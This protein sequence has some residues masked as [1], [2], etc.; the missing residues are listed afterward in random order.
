MGDLESKIY[1]IESDGTD[2]DDWVGD[3]DDPEEITLS[4]TFTNGTDYIVMEIARRVNGQLELENTLSRFPGGSQWGLSLDI[5][6]NP[7]VIQGIVRTS[8]TEA[9]H[10]KFFKT[11]NETLANDIYLIIRLAS[12]TYK[13]FPN[14]SGTMKEYMKCVVKGFQWDYRAEKRYFTV[15]WI[16]EAKWDD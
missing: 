7:V 6:G 3:H 13:Q 11:H 10:E 4:G 16:V 1:L 5:W 9:L 15:K 12:D 14:A 8:A 2:N